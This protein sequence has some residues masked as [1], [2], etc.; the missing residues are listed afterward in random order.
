MIACEKGH[1][2]IIEL[3][4]K[5]GASL[6]FV[7]IEG[8]NALMNACKSGHIRIVELLIQSGC[9]LHHLNKKGDS[10]LLFAIVYGHDKILELLL[11]HGADIDV[12]NNSG[13]Y[14]VMIAC[15][16]GHDK[17]IELLIKYGASLTFFDIEGNNALMNACKSGHLRIVELLIQ[18]GCDLNHVNKKGDS[19]ILIAFKKG[20]DNILDLLLKNNV[21]VKPRGLGAVLAAYKRGNYKKIELQREYSAYLGNTNIDESNILMRASRNGHFEIIDYLIKAGVDVNHPNTLGYCP[22]TIAIEHG[23]TQ[24]VELLIENGAYYYITKEITAQKCEAK[25]AARKK[26]LAKNITI[27]NYSI[28]KSDHHLGHL[29]Q[30]NPL[31]VY[32]RERN[33]RDLLVRSR[34]P[35]TTN[36]GFGTTPCPR[37]CNTCHFTLQVESLQLSKGTLKIKN[38]FNCESRNVVYVIQC[39]RCNIFYIRQTGKRLSDRVSQHLRSINNEDGLPVAKHFNKSGHDLKKDFCVNDQ[40]FSYIFEQ[41][42][43]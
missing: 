36:T 23:F 27:K 39:R 41:A 40:L 30:Q 7:D 13:G 19:A 22:L 14:A 33:L 32:R 6:T 20:H 15:E 31:V 11:K 38:H 43:Y 35:P 28:L 24:I 9:D 10:P 5:Y 1:D 37:K 29:F 16:K 25:T 21:D 3:L 4:I 42:A 8:N 18:S 2:K 26:V 12:I 34:L 17:I